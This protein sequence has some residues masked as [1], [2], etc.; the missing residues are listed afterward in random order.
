MASLSGR[1]QATLPVIGGSPREVADAVRLL[2]QGR[3]QTVKD[4]EL[5]TGA[6]TL[7]EDALLAKESVV[8]VSPTSASAAGLAI[9]ISGQIDGAC[10]LNH[11]TGSAG[12]TVRLGWFG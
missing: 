3:L 4:V 2:S 1:R 6:T 11:P 9:W 5:S 10:T 12:R 7:V 8:L